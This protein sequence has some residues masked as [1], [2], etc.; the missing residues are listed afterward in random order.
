MRKLTRRSFI[1]STLAS[2]AALAL[3][4]LA[5]AEGGT[6]ADIKKRG[7]LVVGTEAAY[8]PFEFVENGQ[9]VGYGH[10]VLELMVAKL[11][12]KLEQMNL[13]FQ[14]LLPGLMSHK[15]DF[16]ATSVGITPE[17]AKRFAFSEP[18][19]VVRSE[20]MV[21][22]DDTSIKQDLDIGGKTI[23]TQMGSSSQPVAD[24]F[25][26]ELKAK[27]GKGYAGTKL[28]QAY[29]D[30]SNALANRTIDVALMPSNIAAVQMKRQPNAFRIVG[31]IGQPKLLAWV[32]NPNDLE[33]RKF[34]N[35]SLDEF[36]TNGKLAALQTKWFG[37]PM[38]TPRAN[39]L[40]AGAI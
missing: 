18:V 14:G 17:R 39:Y 10:D 2:G 16:V 3:P 33:I 27:T 4:S 37:A 38:D 15:F 30:V 7:T 13:P 26:K 25:E 28:F 32:A 19:G 22:A 24:E 12:V 36:R 34:I 23:G 29:P 11:G 1:Q 21:R 35:D 40:P 5:F 31:T 8:E 20:L 9:I 6:L